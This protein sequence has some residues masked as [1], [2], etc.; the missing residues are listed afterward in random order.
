MTPPPGCPESVHGAGRLRRAGQRRHAR[1]SESARFRTKRLAALSPTRSHQRK[2]QS[3]P[4]PLSRHPAGSRGSDVNRDQ[5]RTYRTEPRMT[6]DQA[7]PHC[8]SR[9]VLV[10]EDHVDSAAP[11]FP[12]GRPLWSS[13]CNR[14]H[15]PRVCY[16]GKPWKARQR[17]HYQRP[18]PTRR[19]AAAPHRDVSPKCSQK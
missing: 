5:P 8:R 2:E 10:A 15:A 19:G 12:L 6:G 14:D 9:P 13:P 11:A 7:S 16:G 1:R 17:S 3:P 18:A 4:Q